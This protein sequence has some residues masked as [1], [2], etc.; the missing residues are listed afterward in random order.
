VIDDRLET[1]QTETQTALLTI[2]SLYLPVRDQQS[3][4]RVGN[5]VVFK[6]CIEAFGP[7]VNLLGVLYVWKKQQPAG[8]H[9]CER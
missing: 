5:S 2:A 4:S 9:C 7:I 3:V 8:E 6:L 1:H